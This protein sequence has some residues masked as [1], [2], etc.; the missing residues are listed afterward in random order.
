MLGDNLFQ[1]LRNGEVIDEGFHIYATDVQKLMIGAR[2]DNSGLEA[3]MEVA[4]ALIYDRALTGTEREGVET[5]LQQQF[6][7]SDF[8][9]A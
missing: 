4:A 1:H 5:Y 6:I 2:L 7:D 9:F 8:G 3:Q